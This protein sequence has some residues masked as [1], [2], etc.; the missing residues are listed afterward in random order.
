[1]Y[2]KRISLSFWYP[3]TVGILRLEGRGAVR[4]GHRPCGIDHIPPPLLSQ[5]RPNSILVI[6][7]GSRV[8]TS[9]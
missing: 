3:G 8:S 9:F 4:Q 6:P 2:I 7:I 5:L 1:M